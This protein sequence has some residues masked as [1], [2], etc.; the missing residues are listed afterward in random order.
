MAP[1]NKKLG[2]EQLAALADVQH[3]NYRTRHKQT[4][5]T[6]QTIGEFWS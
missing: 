5:T 6:S 1:S 4:F 3:G 2:A